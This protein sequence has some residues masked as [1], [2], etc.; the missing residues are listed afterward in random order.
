MHLFRR[1]PA[2]NR[3]FCTVRSVTSNNGC[4]KIIHNDKEEK[5]KYDP[6]IGNPIV[7]PSGAK[8]WIKMGKIIKQ[9]PPSLQ[10]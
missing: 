1:L 6:K 5:E 3:Q 7:L 8:I 4:S 10:K 9:E 2:L